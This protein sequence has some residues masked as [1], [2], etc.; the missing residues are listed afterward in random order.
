[1]PDRMSED[2]PE[3][4]P[5]RASEDMPEQMPEDMSDRMPEDLPVTKRIDVMVGIT[6]SKVIL[7]SPPRRETFHPTLQTDQV[8]KSNSSNQSSKTGGWGWLPLCI[9]QRL[10]QIDRMPNQQT[11]SNTLSLFSLPTRFSITGT[12][13]WTQWKGMYGSWRATDRNG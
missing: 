8:S 5:D 13:R 2:M 4:M 6:R 10:W 9:H 1:M 7:L 11:Q 3:D 12:F